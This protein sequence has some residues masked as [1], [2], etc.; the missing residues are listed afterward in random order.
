MA[1]GMRALTVLVVLLLLLVVES[2]LCVRKLAANHQSLTEVLFRYENV[3][4]GSRDHL[5]NNNKKVT[6]LKILAQ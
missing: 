1:V 2:V 5:N 3:E 4:V 6:T